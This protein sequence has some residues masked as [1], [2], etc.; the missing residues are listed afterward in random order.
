MKIT[1]DRQGIRCVGK[2]W[3]IRAYLRRLACHQI[4]LYQFLNRQY[5]HE[6]KNK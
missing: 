5:S 6:Q 3:E 1:T 2:S 4:T